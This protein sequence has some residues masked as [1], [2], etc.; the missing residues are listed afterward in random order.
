MS[1][2]R[3]SVKVFLVAAVAAVIA[4]AADSFRQPDHQLAARSYGTLVRVYQSAVAPLMRKWVRCRFEPTCSEYSLQAVRRYGIRHG[5]QLS[6]A[7]VYR[8]QRNVP[9]GTRDHVANN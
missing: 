7:R 3:Q 9:L 2:L 5:L 4:L 6:L 8:C 1:A